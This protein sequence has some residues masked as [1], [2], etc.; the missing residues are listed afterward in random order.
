[1]KRLAFLVL[2]VAVAALAVLCAWKG[3]WGAAA[4]LAIGLGAAL[5]YRRE[6]KRGEAAEQFFGDLGEETRMTVQQGSPSEMPVDR[7][8]GAAPRDP[9]RG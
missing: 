9:D 5:W 7:A 1:M 6:V 3:Y 2:A 8:P 4:L